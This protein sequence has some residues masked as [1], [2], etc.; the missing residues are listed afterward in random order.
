VVSLRDRLRDRPLPTETVVLP[1]DPPA[2][3]VRQ[4][5]CVAA[6]WELEAARDRASGDL[7]AL[8]ADVAA[9]QAALAELATVTVTLRALP[10]ADWEAL[11]EL[12]PAADADREKGASWGPG[13]RLALLAVSV[14]PDDGDTPTTEAEWEGMAKDGSLGAGEINALFTVAVGLNLRSPDTRVG[15]G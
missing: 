7:A 1:L 9:A 15:K 12:H 3:A 6:E 2:H 10:A 13:F 11:L 4:R 5:Q 8:R 14:V